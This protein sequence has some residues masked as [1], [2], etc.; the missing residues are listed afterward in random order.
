VKYLTACLLAALAT[1]SAPVLADTASPAVAAEIMNIV[2]AQW[3]A[4]NARNVAESQKNVAEEYTEFNPE[5][6]TRLEGRALAARLAEASNKDPATTLANE[7]LNPKVQ[8]YGDVAILSYNF[9]GYAQDKD[10]KVKPNRAKSTRVY[11]RQG[12]KWMLVHANF[13]LDAMPRD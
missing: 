12:G 11:A 6:A 8:V 4:E 2:K 13:G 7:M 5:A 3:L 10:G 9:L 1:V